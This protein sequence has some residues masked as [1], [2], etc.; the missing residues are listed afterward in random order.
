MDGCA[1]IS[2]GVCSVK[3][4][5]ILGLLRVAPNVQKTLRGEVISF[6]PLVAAGLAVLE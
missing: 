2:K 1:L 6:A 4:L 3:N 5:S